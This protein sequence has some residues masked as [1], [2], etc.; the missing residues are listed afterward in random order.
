MAALDILVK[1]EDGWRAYEVKSSTKVSET[2]ELDAS[3]QYYCITNS[4]I[5]LKDIFIVH[6]NNQYIK[7]GPIDV[8]QLFTIESVRK[9][10]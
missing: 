10:V 3:I 1:H 7:N 9:R 5:D 6:I 8:H 2:Y 4:G